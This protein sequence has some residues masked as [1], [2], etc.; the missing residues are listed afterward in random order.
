MCQPC[1]CSAQ[2]PPSSPQK[3]APAL[4]LTITLKE[5]G[6]VLAIPELEAGRD[7]GLIPSISTSGLPKPGQY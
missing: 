3:E 2:P 4:G 6:L 1:V 7:V 5:Q